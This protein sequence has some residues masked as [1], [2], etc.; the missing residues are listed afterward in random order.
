MSTA[1]VRNLN[2]PEWLVEGI[3]PEHCTIQLYGWEGSHK[4]FITIDLMFCVASGRDF[5]GHK[6]RQARG[7]YVAAE[8]GAPIG[9]RIRAWEQHHGITCENV[10]W[11]MDEVLMLD[12]PD[13]VEAAIAEWRG[14]GYGFIVIDTL[15]T[16]STGDEISPKTMGAITR[17]M[18]ML[19]RDL[20][21]T[22][23]IVHHSPKG[24]SHTYSGSGVMGGNI[25]T[26]IQV[27]YDDKRGTTDFACI[28]QK[29]ADKF[30]TI[31]FRHK[32]VLDSLVMTT[33]EHEK[34]IIKEGPHDAL[35]LNLLRKHSDGIAKAAFNKECGDNGIRNSTYYRRIKVLEAQNRLRVDELG[36]LWPA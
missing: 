1:Q 23:L 13:L 28:K 11:L 7:L 10:D 21:T 33:N 3:L 12:N 5:H 29:D 36:T 24:N 27:S 15:R 16:S 8:G 4:S 32:P 20:N 14:K 18:R 17:S 30:E 6:V 25:T 22:V 35:I 19:Q 26:N 34:A 9:K 31:V 2:S